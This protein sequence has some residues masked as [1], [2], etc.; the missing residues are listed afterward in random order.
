MIKDAI[1]I[2][3]V[4]FEGFNVLDVLAKNFKNER[5]IYINDIKRFPYTNRSESE[6]IELVKSNVEFLQSQNIKLLIVTSDIIVDYA[7]SYLDSLNIPVIDVVSLLIEYVN[8]NYE[9]KN[10]VLLAK[11]AIIEANIYQKNFKYNRLYNI[12]SDELEEI[13]NENYLKT[14]KSFIKTKESFKNLIRRDIDVI[15]ASSPYLLFL[16][17]EITEFVNYGEITDC[18]SIIVS[19]L[20]NEFF[21]FNQKGRGFI[22]VY[23]NIEK[24]EFKEK[25]KF[26]KL[27]YKYQKI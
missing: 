24:K 19:K 1:G 17:T 23:S 27:K 10:I 18:G 2:L 16:K 21:N 4:G 22:K 8:D 7:K 13:I 14:S 11:N 25:T 15:V 6:V 3:D 20:K 12:P 5:F 26:I 9:Q